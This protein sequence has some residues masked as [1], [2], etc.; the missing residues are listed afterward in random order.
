MKKFIL[1]GLFMTLLFFSF[2]GFSK[3]IDE[4][5]A[6]KVASNYL[7]RSIFMLK[8]GTQS[9]IALELHT[10]RTMNN[11]LKRGASSPLIYIY[12]FANSNGFILVAADDN[13]T[14]I[15][16]YSTEQDF[17]INAMPAQVAAWMKHYEKE[18]ETAIQYNVFSSVN[19]NKWNEVLNDTYIKTRGVTTAVKPLLTTTWDQGQYYYD[20]CP[21]DATSKKYAYTGCVA[22]AMAQ[23]MKYWNYPSTGNGTKTYTNS[24]S[25]TFKFGTL[26][27]NFGTTTYDWANMPNKLT[28]KNDAVATLMSHV[29]ISIEMQYGL[30][31]SGAWITYDSRYTPYSNGHLSLIN[32]WKYDPSSIKSIYK[33]NY[34]DQTW[35]AAIKAEIDKSRPVILEG[36]ASDGSG[37]HCYVADGYDA[38]NYL[39]IN[40]GWSGAY[41]GYF[42]V[43]NL[44]PS[45]TSTGGGAGVYT[46]NQGA[47][48]GIRPPTSNLPIADFTTSS[49]ATTIGRTVVLSDKSTNIPQS[50]NWNISPST[51]SFI[52]GTSETSKNPEIVFN[53]VGEYTVN[54]TV[55]NAVGSKSLTKE[56][57]VTVNPAL[58]SQ[59]CDTLTN[60]LASE[61]KAY[62]RIKG[63]GSFA[64][65]VSGNLKSFAESYTNLGSYSHITGA[66]LDFARAET[67]NPNST[68]NVNVYAN[69]GGS[70]GSILA[71]KSIKITDIRQDLLNVRETKV[72]FDTPIAVSGQFF[73][74]FEVFYAAGDTVGVYT[75]GYGAAGTNT[76]FLQ[77]SD[78]AWCSYA[79][80]WNKTHLKISPLVA[81]LP[82]AN[83]TLSSST[84]HPNEV[85][86]FSAANA[87]NAATYNWT[88][89]GANKSNSVSQIVN[90]SYSTIGTYEVVLNVTN[91]CGASASK[92]T[93]V[94]VTAS[95]DPG[96]ISGESTVCEGQS[97][98]LTS[99]VNGG[100]W[101]V[102]DENIG[103]INEGT[104]TTTIPGTVVVTY[105]ISNTCKVDKTIIVNAKPEIP[106]LEGTS[107][108]CAGK[109]A[110]LTP[111]I[112]G[113]NWTS[114]NTDFLTVNNGLI[115][116]ILGGTVDVNYTIGVDNCSSTISKTITID[117]QPVQP[118][119]SGPSKICWNGRAMFRASV[120]GGVWGVENSTLLLAS[121]QGLF[122]NST[123]PATDNF[124]SGVNYTIKSKL[125]ACTSK[126]VKSVWVRNVTAPS[127]S[128]TALKTGIKV[129][130]TTT[131]TATTTIA[132]VGTWSS[133]NTLVSATA[134]TTNTKTSA[135]KGLRVG[136][137]ANVVYFADDATTGCRQANWLAFNVTS[138]A[139]MVDA[140]QGS[141]STTT[142]VSV[143]P[144]PSNGK[145]TIENTEG[146]SSVKLVDLSGRVIATKSIITGTTTI[147]FSEVATGKYML[148]ING[149]TINEVQ[150]IVIE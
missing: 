75:T 97:I 40:W 14:P 15:L 32:Y 113:G 138:A 89:T 56:A 121:P 43:S 150:P 12:N 25:A 77:F 68:I 141:S 45:G 134:N 73:I 139:S 140:N 17:D 93:T 95:C 18:I 52:N 47:V 5:T 131:A 19:S 60:F 96:T 128:V 90:N 30:D 74:G 126:V 148:H 70:P 26:S 132:T 48:L 7:S 144:N 31:G 80:C 76:S 79:T 53:N 83:F 58:T 112:T 99:S 130:E 2:S 108:I 1:K 78:G 135:V 104:L 94:I 84:I 35:T 24:A 28:A 67:N 119:I 23:V 142:G 81:V 49:S 82:T 21:Y 61:S 143:Y 127:I 16:G 98:D 37:G 41:N 63:G 13:V 3:E 136:A 20:K 111:S 71:T 64:G 88:F 36:S 51:Y 72:M 117:I 87:T 109:S 105:S 120:A 86:T 147:D 146:A 125:G 124:K 27:A 102:S 54:L 9:S 42:T 100:T 92:T 103:T 107:I 101:S 50:W 116:G 133:T 33:T 123:K 106:S 46:F 4:F 85:V 137:G 65:H 118:L 55:T 149:E 110:T 10:V 22:T 62:I 29:G 115:Q 6:Q 38:N 59:V 122:R 44:V 69:S 8:R 11:P 129:N 114:S 39:H 91:G 145:F 34:T 66:F 57:F